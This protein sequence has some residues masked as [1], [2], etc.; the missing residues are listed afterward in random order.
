MFFVKGQ[1]YH[2][3]FSVAI[4]RLAGDD[5]AYEIVGEFVGCERIDGCDQTMILI[6][7]QETGQEVAINP[8]YLGV[9]EP[10]NEDAEESEDDDEADED[11]SAEDTRTFVEH[12]E[13][14]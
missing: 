3:H 13:P 8:F 9:V 5:V 1:L 7:G 14:T 6:R 11:E 4:E 12:D 10:V 2:W